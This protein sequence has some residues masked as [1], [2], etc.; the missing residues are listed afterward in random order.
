M[1]KSERSGLPFQSGSFL[2]QPSPIKEAIRIYLRMA[3]HS[4]N[5]FRFSLEDYLSLVRMWLSSVLYRLTPRLSRRM[6]RADCFTHKVKMWVNIVNL[7]S[8]SHGHTKTNFMGWD[9]ELFRPN[10]VAALN[11]SRGPQ[12]QSNTADSPSVSLVVSFLLTFSQ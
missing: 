11:G 6:L 12:C 8:G 2:E 4:T 10:K 9:V 1:T 3:V 7:L 5:G